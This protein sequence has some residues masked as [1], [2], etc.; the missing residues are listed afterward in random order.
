MRL[1]GKLLPNYPF[2]VNA[3]QNAN[4]EFNG[5]PPEHVNVHPPASGIVFHVIGK[6]GRSCGNIAEALKQA[7]LLACP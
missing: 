6:L 2:V 3:L 7:A 4:P 5:E 1:R